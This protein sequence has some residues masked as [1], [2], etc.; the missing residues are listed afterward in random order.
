MNCMYAKGL[1]EEQ[2]LVEAEF[3]LLL[4]DGILLG[5]LV[6]SVE[7][8]VTG[9]LLHQWT[10]GS[11]H[12]Q[13]DAEDRFETALKQVVDISLRKVSKDATYSM[14]LPVQTEI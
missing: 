13:T 7:E 4:D 11:L 2:S 14:K 1:L 6:R 9:Q 5:D 8:L 12:G 10:D 3:G